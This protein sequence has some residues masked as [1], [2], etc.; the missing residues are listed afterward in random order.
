MP[1][2]LG[3]HGNHLYSHAHHHLASLGSM[4]QPLALTKHTMV[5]P[6]RST[7]APVSAVAHSASA[8]ER[9][10]V[11]KSHHIVFFYL[12]G[13][14]S[15]TLVGGKSWHFSGFVRHV[16]ES[17]LGDHVCSSQQPQLQPVPLSRHLQQMLQP[18][19][20]LQKTQ[21]WVTHV[22]LTSRASFQKFE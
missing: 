16:T 12:S 3:V 5:E 6:A 10:Q 4:D 20:Q 8:V 13:K 17:P 21:Q 9:Q 14:T 2:A 7:T 15:V 11:N 18:H 19:E 22:F 1:N